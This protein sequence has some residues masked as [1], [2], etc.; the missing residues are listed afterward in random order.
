MIQCDRMGTNVRRIAVGVLAS[1]GLAFT[2]RAGE[3]QTATA[4]AQDRPVLL[5][6]YQD[7]G[8]PAAEPAKPKPANETVKSERTT[9]KTT[10]TTVATTEEYKG[11]SAFFNVREANSNVRAGETEFELS[12]HWS[13]GTGGDDYLAPGASLK[14]GFTDDLFGEIE[15]VPVSLGDGG[16]HG[17][18]DVALILFYQWCHE[19]GDMPA[20]AT[21]LEGR[22]PSGDGSE[23]V[24]GEMHFNL[25]KTWAPGFRGHLE[26]YVKT[27]NGVSGDD[28]DDADI[29][30]FQW[31]VGPG[32]DWDWNDQTVG[33][34]NYVNRASDEYGSSN[35]HVL[36]LGL[37]HALSEDQ[38][39][40]FAFDIN[41]DHDESE[42][43][44]A[45]KVQWSL[46]W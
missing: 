26:G 25:T 7:K 15:L 46:E 34:L 17:A 30:D 40:K 2:V 32:F 13:T 21:W 8:K 37:A 29:R 35:A 5:A 42:P 36:E 10:E 20:F 24:D 3:P 39:L 45:A 19:S 43:D 22:F 31:G 41:L 12:F 23:G 44:F 16:D 33:I 14:Y 9:I 27:A 11:V 18:G 4:G 6:A 28:D 1:C 38:H